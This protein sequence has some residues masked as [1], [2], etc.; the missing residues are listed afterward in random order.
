MESFKLLMNSIMTAGLVCFQLNHAAASSITID[1]DHLASLP[2]VT[3]ASSFAAANGGSLTTQGVTFASSFEV[4]GDQYRINGSAPNPT[5]G[6]PTSGHYFLS[7][8]NTPNDNLLIQTT[9][10]LTEAW[11]GR[12]EYYGYG[13][14][15]TSVTVTA[16]GSSGDLGSE[17]TLLPDT[18]PYTGNL[19]GYSIGNGLPDPLVQLDTSSFLGLSG[20][21]GY[22]ISR[23]ATGQFNGDWVGDD[24]T[25]ENASTV[26][27]PTGLGLFSIGLIGLAYKLRRQRRISNISSVEI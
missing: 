27:E 24:F 11:F 23:V 10:V 26:P 20:I 13:G 3:A 8:G 17:T 22:R 21:T 7:N 2:A 18:Y 12:N 6:V 16:F 4:V 9:L 19:P 5:F 25:F 1:F 15:A 14:G